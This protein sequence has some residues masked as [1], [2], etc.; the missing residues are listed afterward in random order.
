MTVKVQVW[1]A[2]F[3]SIEQMLR[4]TEQDLYLLHMS[5]VVREFWHKI[6]ETSKNVSSRQLHVGGFQVI[7][8][9]MQK[10]NTHVH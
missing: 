4:K 5:S 8:Y 10:R 2:S 3:N 1:S 7:H 9:A 6:I